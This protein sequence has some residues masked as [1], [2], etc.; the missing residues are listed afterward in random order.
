MLNPMS[1]IE[2]T[3]LIALL[4]VS[5]L[6]LTALAIPSL[7]IIGFFLLLL[8]GL[9]LALSPAVALYGWLFAAP[10]GALR[11]L[12]LG[13]WVA[14]LPALAGPLLVGFALPERSNAETR[15]AL[16]AA[17]SNDIRPARPLPIGGTVAL[18][19]DGSA[20]GAHQRDNGCDDLCLRLLFNGDAKIVYLG[21][22]GLPGAAF[23]VERL[24]V[25]PPFLLSQDVLKWHTWPD[26]AAGKK[27]LSW[28][29]PPGLKEV[30][31]ARIAGGECL[32]RVRGPIRPDWTI[33]R[34]ALAPRSNTARWSIA[35]QPAQETR[36][37]VYRREG[38]TMR[39]VGRF[40][41]AYAAMLSVPLRPD[42]AG[43]M[44]NA[45]FTWSRRT[46]GES[47]WDWDSVTALR[48]LVAFNADVPEGISPAR[49]RDLLADALA[50]PRRGRD[51]AGLLL[52]NA[53]MVD[54]A[55]NDAK[56]GDADLL[57]KAIA[58][59]RL[60]KIEPR[61]E[62][63]GKLGADYTTIA[64]SAI[65][66]LAR[67]PASDP[68]NFPYRALNTIVA[69]MPAPWFAAPPSTLTD[70]L[71]DPFIAARSDG[72]IYKLD[73][74]G[75][76]AVP[77]LTEIVTRG[78][79]RVSRIEDKGYARSG[80]TDGMQ[81]AVA[82]LCRIGPPARSA[83]GPIIAAKQKLIGTA[84]RWRDRNP[85]K[86]SALWQGLKVNDGFV[87]TLVS[88]GVPITAFRAPDQPSS[89]VNGSWQAMILSEVKRND[90]KL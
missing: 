34:V 44:E 79:E 52:A 14:V 90:C 21:Q 36:I 23:T 17:A 39:P 29:P 58:D 74:G 80:A 53:V 85:G 49:M 15:A 4:G 71:R 59:D 20:G 69:Q 24:A 63:A 75:A 43:G 28:P 25:C 57:A 31:E 9:I 38:S 68:A 64:D 16:A 10:Y 7:V 62:I 56:A 61:H 77:L 54:I 89:T 18:V 67:L 87:V 27:G 22:R 72:I 30:V 19:R 13:W 2:K 40:T 26:R 65:A 45:H 5:V 50:D 81:A 66:R 8:P 70:L 3:C 12:G 41:N 42:M 84:E 46:I 73:A 60:T 88:F 51:D 37:T 6:A 33:E 35:P 55:R 78:A 1:G 48:T 32:V 82:A 11:V 76:A 86:Y 83:L 47:R